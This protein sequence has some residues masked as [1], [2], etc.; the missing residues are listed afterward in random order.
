MDSFT[1]YICQQLDELLRK[2]RLVVFYDP[3][4]EFEPLFDR[5]LEV[6]GTGYD[7]LPRVF[8]E[9]RRTFVVRYEGSFFGLRSTIEPIVAQDKPDPLIVYLPGIERDREASVL[10][11]LEKAGTPYEPQ[12][13][14]LA[15]NVLRK[16][17]TDGQIDEMLH[18]AAVGYDDVVSFLQQADE[19]ASASILRTIFDGAQSEA[20]MSCWLAEDH[21]DT[22]IL[23]KE[24]TDE[25]FKLI[26]SRIG[27]SI[28]P[29]TRLDDARE[30]VCRYA[31]VNEFRTDLEGEPPQVVSMI[32]TPPSK[33][34]DSRIGDVVTRLRQG[35][36][37]RYIEIADR[38]EAELAL[39]GN[40]I[41]ATQ[42]GTTDTFRF[43]ERL[44]LR[45]AGEYICAQEY[46]QALTVADERQRSFWVDRDVGRQAQ[47]EA[48]RLMADLGSEVERAR[49][50]L[51]RVKN[52]STAWVEAYSTEDGWHAADAIQRRLEAWVAKMDEEPETEQALAVVRLEYE[53][54]LK[55]MA[56]GFAKA[57]KESGWAVPNALQQTDIYSNV[58]QSK[59]KRVAYL[60]VDAMRFDMGVELARQL[61]DAIDLSIRPAIAMLPT[62][63][64]VGMAA[65]LPGASASFSVVEHKGKLAA[66][67]EG[68]IMPGLGERQKFLKARVP[69]AVDLSLGDLLSRPPARLKNTIGR[70]S[71]VV[72][73]S[74]DIDALGENLDQLMAR[75]AM[76][77]AIGNVARAIRK[78]SSLGIEEFV[79][80]SDHG[81]QFSIRKDDDMKTDNPGG[82]TVGFHRRCWIGHGG[83]NPP[84]TVRVSGAELGY[85]TNLD[86]V[87]CSGLGVFK[88]G[89][90]LSYHHGGLSLQE[91]VIPVLSLRIPARDSDSSSASDIVNLSDVP[92]RLTNRTFGV[93]VSVAGDL[94]DTEPVSFRVILVAGNEQVG[95]AGMVVGGELDR[96]S[97]ILRVMPGG[98]ANVGVMLTRDDCESVR[99]IVLDPASDAVL[100]QSD[101]IPVQLGI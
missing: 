70:A 26:E 30:R 20:L 25:L 34:H 73:R 93:T 72:V 1:G 63:T 66:S 86:F 37:S 71:L 53:E 41:E 97:G 87:L 79:V 52:N 12:L 33:D 84:G 10:M 16:Q 82:D 99:T 64:P 4:R 61:E 74:Q 32:P 3:R 59:G 21:R 46:Q 42:L 75:A 69:D 27:M 58:L 76:E 14:R 98:E 85:D 5:E 47:W 49:A 6:V 18:S 7:G 29:D 50:S 40:G 8:V 38:I 2:R 43:E 67:V 77:G 60:L 22:Q 95:Q 39:T 65:L 91:V 92:D 35:F 101:D 88:S 83:T 23:E 48:C 51:S 28:Q 19:T 56:A 89:G 9:E 57:L 45:S 90:G 81:H 62:I 96:S 11:E 94:F 78:L 68:T 31:L 55:S 24:A 17:F 54:L 13:K 100:A 44:L 15:L 80:T 36:P